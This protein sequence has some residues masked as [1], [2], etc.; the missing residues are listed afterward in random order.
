MRGQDPHG[1]EELCEDS[2]HW[3]GGGVAEPTSFW[4]N[5]ASL[6]LMGGRGRSG[7][8]RADRQGWWSAARAPAST[9]AYL[10]GV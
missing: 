7:V 10:R 1:E 3:G 8:D 4:M 6:G 5:T 9:L 2:I